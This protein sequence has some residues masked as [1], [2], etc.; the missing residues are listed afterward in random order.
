MS[1]IG[2][3]PVELP[4]GVTASVSGQTIEVKGPK[5]T[6]SFSATDDVT[7]SVED[8]VVKIDPRGSSKRAR[9]Q[10]GMS[11]TMV[12]NLVTGVTSGFKK[13]LEIQGV[14]Y[15]AQMQGNTLKLNLGLSH[16]VDYTAPEGVTITAPKQTEIVVEGIDEQAVGQ[17]AAEIRAWRK[18][19][20][21]K[22]KGIRYKGEFIFRK[23]GK[24]K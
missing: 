1:R 4:S 15:R 3:K 7:L 20:P 24:K 19:E 6:R 18:P 9:Q 23:E 16:D 11:R 10:W 2:K 12:A 8:N 22:G 21:Y 14:G 5:G 13:E 17:V